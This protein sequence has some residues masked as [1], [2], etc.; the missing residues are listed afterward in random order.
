LNDEF[1]ELLDLPDPSIAVIINNKSFKALL[2]SGAGACIANKEVFDHAMKNGAEVEN[3]NRIFGLADGFSLSK[4]IIRLKI[5]L[6][7][8]E[9]GVLCK[10][11][12]IFPTCLMTLFLVV[13]FCINTKLGFQ[14]IEEHFSMRK[15]QTYTFLLAH[16]TKSSQ[17]ISNP[18]GCRR[19]S[20]A[21]QRNFN[22]PSEI[23]YW[24][25]M[26]AACLTNSLAWL[27]ISFMKL[28]P[29]TINRCV[30]LRG[31]SIQSSVKC[32]KNASTI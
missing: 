22:A 31:L 14:L 10:N 28:T 8:L 11:S 12:L 32:L 15:N 27:E 13:I 16:T 30:A 29:G 3:D 19:V 4:K 20:M 17:L 5:H 9:R 2:D 21:C 1:R 25:S 26:R 18:H 7:G 6:P 24:S 23:Y